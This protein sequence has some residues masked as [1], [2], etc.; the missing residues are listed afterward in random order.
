MRWL[1]ASRET[2][3][4]D[5]LWSRPPGEP[6]H[7]SHPT[8][9]C[10]PVQSTVPQDDRSGVVSCQGSRTRA[11]GLDGLLVPSLLLAYAMHRYAAPRVSL[12]TF[13]VVAPASAV[14]LWRALPAPVGSHRAR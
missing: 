8:P 1:R 11:E 2:W 14:A 12:R 7:V 6:D 9:E 5:H 4:A 13:S 3:I 10:R